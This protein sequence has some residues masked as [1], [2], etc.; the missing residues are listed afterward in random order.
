[1]KR[2]PWLVPDNLAAGDRKSLRRE[3]P[4]LSLEVIASPSASGFAPTY[5]ALWDEFGASGEMELPEVLAARMAWKPEASGAAMLY[6]MMRVTSCGEFAAATDQTAI[7]PDDG[8]G[9]IVH[10]SHMLV[11]PAWRRTGLAGWVRAL[12]LSTAR[13]LVEARGLAPDTAITIVGEMEHPD[14]AIPATHARLA[15]VEKAGY[16]KVDPARAGY[17][18]P[19]FRPHHEI[20][21]GGPSP[22]PLALVLRRVGREKE[23][24]ISGAELRRCVSALYAMYAQG[25]RAQDAD[26]LQGLLANYPAPDERVRLVPPTS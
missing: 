5:G 26:A 12:P 7:L 20:G 3:W 13:R 4:E 16:R 11:A 9:V 18:Q 10:H 6:E 2:P 8:A 17:V 24:E 19:D 22:L 21:R 15:A 25:M 14:P 1:M 23:E